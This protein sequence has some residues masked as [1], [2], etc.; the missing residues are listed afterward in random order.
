MRH[1]S[2]SILCLAAI[3]VAFVGSERFA[4]AD[5]GLGVPATCSSG[6]PTACKQETILTCTHF[7]TT[8]IPGGTSYTCD[9]WLTTKTTWYW[10]IEGGGGGGATTPLPKK[11][12]T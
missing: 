8:T 10:S 1:L 2:R 9:S 4:Y 3:A 6:S 11:A 5:D 7:N 12:L